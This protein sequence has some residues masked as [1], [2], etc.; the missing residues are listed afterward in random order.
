METNWKDKPC[1]LWPLHKNK[2]GY[3]Q[4]YY[5]R[6]MWLTHRAEW[7]KQNGTIP[8]GI[9]VLH[10]CDNRACYE[11]TH[12]FLGTNQDNVDDKVSKGRQHKPIGDKNPQ[13]KLTS[14]QVKEIREKYATGKYL[15]TYLAVIYGV[16]NTNISEIVRYRTWNGE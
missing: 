7:D 9:H 15:Q 10:H 2:K 4:R 6:K 14:E 1:K 5:K 8:N 11:I 13:R 3:G 16:T 12:L